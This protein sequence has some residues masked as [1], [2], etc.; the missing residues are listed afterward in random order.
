MT[1][2]QSFCDSS[3]GFSYLCNF[4]KPGSATETHL[5]WSV[6]MITHTTKW[7]NVDLLKIRGSFILHVHKILTFSNVRDLASCRESSQCPVL[8]HK[9]LSVEA[10][11]LGM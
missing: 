5:R 4:Q 8:N 6:M 3:Y 1:Y 10:K 11:T 2:T 9:L 7:L